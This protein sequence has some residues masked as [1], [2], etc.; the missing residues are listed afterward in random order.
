VVL[1]ACAQLSFTSA[2]GSASCGGMSFEPP[3]SPPF[4]GGL[5]DT[6]A[7]GTKIADLGAG[8]AYFGGGDSEYFPAAQPSTGDTLRF[9]ATSCSGDTFPLVASS[10][11]DAAHCIGGPSADVKVCLNDTTRTCGVDTDCSTVGPFPNSYAFT[12][13]CAQ[14]PRC[15]AGAPYAFYSTLANACVI[16]V[17]SASAT[18]SVGPATG[19]VSYSL[20]TNNIVYINLSD[21]FA[22]YP[23]PRCN[24]GVCVGGVRAGQPCTPSGNVNQTSVDCL[25]RDV[26]FFTFVPGGVA[27]LTTAPRSLGVSNG[28]FCPGQNNPGAFGEEDVR[29]IEL[30]GTPAGS[31]LDLAPHA[32][33]FLS[34]GCAP[35]SGDPMVD[36]L[37]DLPGPAASSVTGLLQLQQ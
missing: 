28:L 32:A 34:L 13:R 6:A 4:A 10:G 3:P 33:T 29:R 16:P 1:D 17:S 35:A 30:S 12:G 11:G 14:A 36:S 2:A 23:C 19:E 21:I 9:D 25:P 7:G 27:S 8:C 18:G 24:A 5:F 31:L 37:A 26:D 22:T 20:G 15:F